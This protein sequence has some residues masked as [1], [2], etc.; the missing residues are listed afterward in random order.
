MQWG[1]LLAWFGSTCPLRGKHRCKSVQSHSDGSHLSYDKTFLSWWVWSLSRWQCRHPHEL[2]EWFDEYEND[3]NNIPWL[4]PDL[5]LFEHFWE[6]FVLDSALYHYNQNTNWRKERYFIRQ[7]KHRNMKKICQDALKLLWQVMAAL[8]FPLM[9]HTFLVMLLFL[10][11]LQTD[12]T[13]WLD[14]QALRVRPNLG[15]ENVDATANLVCWDVT[16][17]AHHVVSL[18]D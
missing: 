9:C 10:E 13:G 7:Y 3:G 1:I 14:K 18:N 15:L 11:A 4:L 16:L 5:K 6:I 12:R 8:V 2:S 17:T